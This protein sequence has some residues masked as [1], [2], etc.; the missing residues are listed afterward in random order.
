[1]KQRRWS[2]LALWVLVASTQAAEPAKITTEAVAGGIH[3]IRV[4][5]AANIV[6]SAGADG[7][8]MVDD[9]D[10]AS[11]D[12]VIATLGNLSKQP[13]RYVINTHVHPDHSGGNDRFSTLVPIIANRNVLE[14]MV[15]GPEK[16]P[17]EARPTMTF[18]SE[19][20][21]FFNGEQVRLLKLPAGHTDGDVV[22][23]FTKSKVVA[24][25]DVFMSPAASFV[26]RSNGGT[27]VGLITAL[28]FLLPQI[29][30]DA[31]IIPGHGDISTRADV[32]RGLDVL[33]EMKGM[34]EAAIAAGKTQEQL[35]AEKP[36][37]KFKG[38][39]APWAKTDSY[40]GRFY[41][42]LKPGS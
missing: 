31:K 27:I 6:V 15:N 33:K 42:E 35:I 19:V 13:P 34:V 41:K 37:E 4:P 18:D 12:Q 3:L 11:A 7:I 9:G 14:R 26:D 29:P 40:V 20:E 10:A 23:L 21:L 25:G 30:A 36:F 2:F 28:E 32:A 8:M 5:D 17:I 24:T 1:M 38:L 22:V 16:R 39:I